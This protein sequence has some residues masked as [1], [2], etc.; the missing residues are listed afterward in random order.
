MNEALLVKAIDAKTA[1][2]T[3]DSIKISQ[4]DK[5]TFVFQSSDISSGNGIFSVEVSI[6]GANWITYNKLIDNVAN[7]NA[8]T[9]LRVASKTLSTNTLVFVSMSPEDVFE[10]CRVKLDMTTDGTYNAW[11][12]RQK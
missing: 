2:Y 7:T 10:F 9:L 11:V 1:D 4:A 3:S 5:V 6:D 8:Q 12:L